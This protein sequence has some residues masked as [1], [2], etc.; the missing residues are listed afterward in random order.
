MAEHKRKSP[1]VFSGRDAT[2]SRGSFGN[3][4]N[5][6]QSKCRE[7]CSSIE[8]DHQRAGAELPR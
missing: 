5:R 4:G 7:R 2:F 8:R 3:F 1:L 6:S